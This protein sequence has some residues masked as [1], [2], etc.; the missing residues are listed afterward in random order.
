MLSTVQTPTMALSNGTKL[1][2]CAG[3][4][5]SYGVFR[6]L[7]KWCTPYFSPSRLL[8]GPPKDNILIGNIK[9]FDSLENSNIHEEWLQEYGK[10]V[11]LKLLLN[12]GICLF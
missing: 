2:A 12:V 5:V 1:A 6:F 4:L 7:K 10:V 9:T 8:R 3:V 11:R